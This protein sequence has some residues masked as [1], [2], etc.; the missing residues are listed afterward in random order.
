MGEDCCEPVFRDDPDRQ[1]FLETLAEACLKTGWQVH[2]YCLM[3]DHFDLVAEWMGW[4]H[5]VANRLKTAKSA[6]SRD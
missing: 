2:A 4:R 1:R 5:A 6:N 3:P